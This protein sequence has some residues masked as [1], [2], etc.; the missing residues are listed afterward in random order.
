MRIIGQRQV[1]GEGIGRQVPGGG[2][3]VAHHVG[4]EGRVGGVRPRHGQT[5]TL[6]FHAAVLEPHLGLE[7]VGVGGGTRREHKETRPVKH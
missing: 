6:V 4:V 1:R 7:E 3:C 2:R 5:L